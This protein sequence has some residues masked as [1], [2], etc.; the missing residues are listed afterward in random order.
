MTQ[1]GPPGGG[2][3]PAPQP[4]PKGASIVTYKAALRRAIRRNANEPES[5]IKYADG[6]FT[7]PRSNRSFSLLD[8]AD[9]GKLAAMAEL[10]HRI[11]AHPTGCAALS[12]SA[13]PGLAIRTIRPRRARSS[14]SPRPTMPARSSAARFISWSWNA[15]ATAGD[16][17]G[18]IGTRMW[19]PSEPLVLTKFVSP[20]LS[21]SSCRW[22]ASVALRASCAT[23]ASGLS[24]APS[25]SA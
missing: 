17:P 5:E 20:T 10:S 14:R 7:T 24:A 3:T 11:P 13:T 25:A 9:R 2:A 1:A 12:A 6:F 19:I 18:F 16:C 15:W 23:T 4:R 22:R 21:Q 8:L